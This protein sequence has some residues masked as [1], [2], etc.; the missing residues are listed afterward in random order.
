MADEWKYDGTLIICSDP[1]MENGNLLKDAKIHLIPK[2]ERWVFLGW[3][4][5]PLALAHPTF[6]RIDFDHVMRQIEFAR[7]KK[8]FKPGKRDNFMIVS[9]VCAYYE[10]VEEIAH[11]KFTVDDMMIDVA[12]GMNHLRSHFR[13]ATAKGFF[14]KPGR[15]G[16]EQIH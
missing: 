7:K 1:D 15:P 8:N 16:F 3:L 10:V 5:A 9:H 13:G 14:K 2:E 4:G 12:T 6:L 11:R